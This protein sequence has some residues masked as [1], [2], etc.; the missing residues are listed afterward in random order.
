MQINDYFVPKIQRLEFIDTK[1]E[2]R[3]GVKT[4]LGTI[5]T[6]LTD[7]AAY[8]F[9]AQLPDWLD[10]NTLREKHQ[11][12]SSFTPKRC[13]KQLKSSLNLDDNQADTL[14]RKV[15]ALTA[16]E[17]PGDLTKILAELPEEWEEIFYQSSKQEYTSDE[18]TL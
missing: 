1:E 6:A 5:T 9:T 13:I 2:A 12:Q 11:S 7:D 18:T 10:Y 17:S 4:V 15:V 14:M 16:Q 3:S 8:D